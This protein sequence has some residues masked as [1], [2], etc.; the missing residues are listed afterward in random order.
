MKFKYLKHVELPYFDGNNHWSI[1]PYTGSLLKG[2]L[3][4]NTNH[5]KIPRKVSMA[6]E[7]CNQ[8]YLCNVNNEIVVSQDNFQLFAELNKMHNRLLKI[9]NKRF[10]I[11]RL[12]SSLRN[13]IFE[14]T[15][16]AI[17]YINSLPPQVEFK[18]KLCLQRAFLAAKISKSFTKD[19]VIFI[20]AFLPTGDMHA[21]IIENGKQPDFDD[22]GW[23]N[24]RPLL[25]LYY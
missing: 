4:K 15:N 1:C 13:L 20:G 7:Y 21:W 24:Y 9:S 14:N 6:I 10:Y 25:A 22:R 18:H 8:P 3:I 12:Y 5:I 2:N 17:T 19:G 16:E 23:I 11:T